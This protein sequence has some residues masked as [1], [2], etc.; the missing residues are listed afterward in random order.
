VSKPL[1]LFTVTERAV[2]VD[3]GS[4]QTLFRK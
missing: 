3:N 4:Y 2:V 1:N